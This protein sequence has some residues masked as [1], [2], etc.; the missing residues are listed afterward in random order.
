MLVSSDNPTKVYLNGDQIYK[1]TFHRKFF[2]DQETVPDIVLN[3]GLNVLVLK[4]VNEH[5][6]W[7]S[8]IRFTDAQGT[9]VDG[10]KVTLDPN[11]KDS[12]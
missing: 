7:H 10:I 8:S 3:A 6:G 4:V 2:A 1:C 5:A 9:P 11:A 12:P